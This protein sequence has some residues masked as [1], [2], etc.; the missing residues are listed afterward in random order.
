M[1]NLNTKNNKILA[2]P[3]GFWNNYKAKHPSIAQF[4][5]FFMLSNGITVLQLV[6]MPVFKSIFAKTALVTTSFQILQFGHNF[7]GSAYYVFDYAAGSLG[8]GGG[9]GLAY[10]LAVQITIAIAQIINF[11]AQRSITF[12]SNSNIWTAAFWYF[13]AYIVITIGAAAAQG[14]YKAP[15]YNLLMNTWGMGSVGETTADVITMI[16]NSAISFWV[17]FPIFKIIF[18]QEPEKQA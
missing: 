5:V 13:V 12:K 4:L 18:K 7:D 10:F 11:F 14:F 6:L 8:S 2:G 17:F 15:I 3:L 9:G 16:I 1:S